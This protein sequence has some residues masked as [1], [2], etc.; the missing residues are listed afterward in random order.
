ML[1]WF[2]SFFRSFFSLF[3]PYSAGPRTP[4]AQNTTVIGKLIAALVKFCCMTRKLING[5]TKG[6]ERDALGLRKSLEKGL[7]SIN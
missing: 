3:I 2:F 6:I 4:P 1:E 7:V 5:I